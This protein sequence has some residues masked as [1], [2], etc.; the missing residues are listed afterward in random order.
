MFKINYSEEFFFTLI[1][2]MITSFIIFLALDFLVGK[3]RRYY[4]KQLK[5]TALSIIGIIELKDP[6]TKGH[7]IRVANYSNILAEATNQYNEADL[8]RFH[9]AC[10]LHDI[11]KIGIPDTILN[12]NSSLTEEEYNVIRKHP[13]FGVKVLQYLSLVDKNIAVIR[14]H[15]EKWDGTGYPDGLKGEQI[16]FCARIVA[17][18]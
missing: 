14:S 7:S 9:F 17:I 15:H 6:Y 11:G 3:L 10:L 1:S 13:I 18:V 5:E 12:K 4:E 2:V 8:H 16:P